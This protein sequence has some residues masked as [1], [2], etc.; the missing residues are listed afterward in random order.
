M[1]RAT[2]GS[3]AHS[4]VE[5]LWASRCAT[6]VPHDPAPITAAQILIAQP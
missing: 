3:R 4:T 6:V 1:P 2:S 5:L